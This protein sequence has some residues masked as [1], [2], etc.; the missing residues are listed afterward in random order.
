MKPWSELREDIRESNRMQATRAAGFLELAGYRVEC[1]SVPIVQPELQPEQI[2]AMAEMEHGRW[3]AERAGAGWRYAPNRNP[4][5]KLSPY[6]VSWDKLSEEVRGYDRDA[7]KAWP[8]VLAS[9]GLAIVR[10]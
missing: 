10:K 5:M 3:V 6:L 8:A 4:E 2:E 1:G 7:V 9:A